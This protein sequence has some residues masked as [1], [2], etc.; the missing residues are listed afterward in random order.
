MFAFLTTTESPPRTRDDAGRLESLIAGMASGDRGALEELY[1]TSKASVYGFALSILRNPQNAEDAM[2]DAFVKIYLAAGSYRPQGKP[3]AWILTIVRNLCLMKLREG[4][5][6]AD[7]PPDEAL[8]PADPNDF[9]ESSIDRMVLRGALT[10]LSDEERQIVVLHAVTG[11][12][13]RE[14]SGIL[15]LPL[16]TVL[17]KYRRAVAKLKKH[18]EEETAK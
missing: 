6:A 13:H 5:R 7:A 14:I 9:T 12:R 8:L 16:S 1:A 11:L 15:E 10:R 17:S 4:A 18:L 2:Q 3:M